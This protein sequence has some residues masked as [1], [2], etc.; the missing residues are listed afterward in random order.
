MAENTYRIIIEAGG[1]GGAGAPGKS[2]VAEAPKSPS[3]TP[4]DMSSAVAKQKAAGK[5]IAIGALTM[6]VNYSHTM[7]MQELNIVTGQTQ[8]AQRRQAQ[9][10]LV[11]AGLNMMTSGISGGMIASFLGVSGP[12]GAVIGIVTAVGKKAIDLGVKSNELNLKQYVEDEQ[13]Q[14]LRTRAGASFNRSRL[15]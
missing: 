15:G 13:I 9:N 7:K 5:A 4:G 6:A 14:A 3:S 1:E 10:A 12:V 11:N 8:L 2:P